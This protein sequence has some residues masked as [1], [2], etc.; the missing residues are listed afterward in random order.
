MLTNPVFFHRLLGMYVDRGLPNRLCA[1][2]YGHHESSISL[3]DCRNLCLRTIACQGYQFRPLVADVGDCLL[4]SRNTSA[5]PYYD[6]SQPTNWTYY[7]PKFI[8]QPC[9]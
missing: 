8:V 5:A 1:W 4:V 6:M 9:V 3:A 2:P 7:A